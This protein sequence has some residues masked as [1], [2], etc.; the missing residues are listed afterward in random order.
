MNIFDGIKAFAITKNT[1]FIATE[2]I[3]MVL[4]YQKKKRETK[5]GKTKVKK[6]VGVIT[7]KAINI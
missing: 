2:L 3:A 6:V 7:E 5:E 4:R 1:I